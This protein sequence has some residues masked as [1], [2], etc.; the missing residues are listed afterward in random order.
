M[1]G[2]S[3]TE[4]EAAFFAFT[5]PFL[6]LPFVFRVD[7]SSV[8]QHARAVLSG[9]ITDRV[10][11]GG[12]IEPHLVEYNRNWH[13][14]LRPDSVYF[15]EQ[16]IEVCDAHMA[17][18][19]AHIDEVG[20]QMLPHSRWCPWSSELRAEVTDLVAANLEIDSP[21]LF[22]R[23]AMR[24]EIESGGGIFDM[25]PELAGAVA[26]ADVIRGATAQAPGYFA[27]NFDKAVK[28]AISAAGINAAPSR[29]QVYY[30]RGVGKSGSGADVVAFTPTF[31][32]VLDVGRKDLLGLSV[33]FSVAGLGDPNFPDWSKAALQVLQGWT[34]GDIIRPAEAGV[35]IVSFKV[36]PVVT[37]AIALLNKY[38]S[39]PEQ[40]IGRHFLL[41]TPILRERETG[42]AIKAAESAI[43]EWGFNSVLR[44]TVVQWRVSEMALSRP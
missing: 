5:Q 36:E 31:V 27:L 17:Y 34:A 26:R 14:H 12:I 24:R 7:A 35:I 21:A 1:P 18:I 30:V 15:F 29:V 2:N 43:D 40:L 38:G 32:W 3:Q 42:D 16:S 22:E 37:D 44:S 13:F 8:I 39:N 9:Q 20:G 11:P 23:C 4:E 10:H 6:P 41:R 19:E 28:H 33:P 25:S